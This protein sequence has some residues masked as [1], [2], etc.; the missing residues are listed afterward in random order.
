VKHQQRHWNRLI[1]GFLPKDRDK[2]SVIQLYRSRALVRTCLLSVLLNPFLFLFE[3]TAWDI[4]QKAGIALFLAV[5]P[6]FIMWVYRATGRL[7]FC[8]SLYVLYCTAVCGWAQLTAATVHAVYWVWIPFLVVFTVL[9]LGVREGAVYTILATILFWLILQDNLRYGHSIGQFSD[10]NALFSSVLA[11]VIL[12]QLCFLLLMTAYDVIRNRTEVRAVL[13]RFTDDEAARLATV[14][15]SMG[16]MA[17]ELNEQLKQFQGQIA[18]LDAVAKRSD[19][20][21]EDLQTMIRELQQQT[22]KLSE[23]SHSANS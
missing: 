10:H 20:K 11:Q 17:Q 7:K 18:K 4:W 9:V 13:L 14:G 12:I 23:I 3:S 8:G 5:L 15:E 6:I 16:G 21:V 19:T 22:R 2:L 1:D